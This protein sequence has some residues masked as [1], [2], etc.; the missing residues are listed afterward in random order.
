MS[1]IG[2][3]RR[4]N[5]QLNN[6][7]AKHSP[8]AVGVVA[9]RPLPDQRDL[10]TLLGRYVRLQIPLRAAMDLSADGEGGP[11]PETCPTQRVA[12]LPSELDGL[13]ACGHPRCQGQKIF[14][15]DP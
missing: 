15:R 11:I 12:R 10:T 2:P 5:T 4:S 13:E 7:Y 8:R 6:F 1:Q 9:V 14:V 3:E